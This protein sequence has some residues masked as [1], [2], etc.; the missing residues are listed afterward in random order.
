MI[1]PF[2]L[3]IVLFMALFLEPRGWL[4]YTMLS[5]SKIQWCES[6]R[7]IKWVAAHCRAWILSNYYIDS[8]YGFSH[9]IINN[10][11]ESNQNSHKDEN[12][13][14]NHTNID[15]NNQKININN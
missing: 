14:A 9:N 4:N 2:D 8:G 3:I 10:I 12:L 11:Q 5:Q 1:F 7:C 15:A 13:D 6:M